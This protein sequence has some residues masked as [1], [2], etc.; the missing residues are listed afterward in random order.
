M[1]REQ[2]LQRSEVMVA[3][4]KGAEAQWESSAGRWN[5]IDESCSWSSIFDVR[6]KPQPKLRPWKREEVPLNAWFKHKEGGAWTRITSISADS[7][8]VISVT[9]GA[10]LVTFSALLETAEHSIDGGQKWLPCGVME[11]VK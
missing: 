5:P 6:I 11:D 9:D 8:G 4:A 3:W 2:A 1:T 10:R 7:V